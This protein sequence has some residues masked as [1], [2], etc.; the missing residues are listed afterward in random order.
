MRLSSPF[1][2]IM[3]KTQVVL[4]FCFVLDT[5]DV[6]LFLF[7]EFYQQPLSS[8][9]TSI[10]QLEIQHALVVKASESSALVKIIK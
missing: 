10:R 6:D 1:Q 7:S 8:I 5:F 3:I 4:L 9:R 2:I